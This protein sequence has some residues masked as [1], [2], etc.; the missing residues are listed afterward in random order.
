MYYNI[1]ASVQ[2]ASQRLTAF[3]FLSVFLLTFQSE[4]CAD[5]FERSAEEYRIKG[6]EEQQKGHFRSALR[7]YSKALSLG[8]TNAVVCN[9]MGILYEQTGDFPRAEEF[10]SKAIT[11]DRDYLPPYTNLAYFY[12]SQ[13]DSS[14]AKTFFH[15]RL[16][17]A[18]ADDPWAQQIRQELYRIDPAYLKRKIQQEARELNEQLVQSARDEFVLQVMRADTHFQRGQKYYEQEDY[19]AAITE[20]DRALSLT[21][22]NPKL[23]KTREKAA[24]RKK[25]QDLRERTQSALRH[26]DLGDTE[27]AQE[28]FQE[29]LDTIPEDSIPRPE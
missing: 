26:L 25:V 15:E 17:R 4:C 20:F 23:L 2:R 1:N 16:K 29:I 10:Y 5:S 3:L 18:P 9:D 28:E 27:A 8:L 13:G 7:F 24:Y 14:K 6:Y 12:L 11:F 22:D 19:S 21:P